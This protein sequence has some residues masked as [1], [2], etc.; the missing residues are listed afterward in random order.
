MKPNAASH[1]NASWYT[2]T[3]GLLTQQGKPV[4]QGACPPEDNSRVFQVPPCTKDIFPSSPGQVV[5]VHAL[6]YHQHFPNIA[7]GNHV[8]NVCVLSLSTIP[9]LLF[10]VFTHFTVHEHSDCM[11]S[12]TTVN[13]SVMNLLAHVFWGV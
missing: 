6:C 8:F 5:H 12:F 1:N 2:D 4:L 3:D 11:Q 10:V 7:L 13:K 9:N